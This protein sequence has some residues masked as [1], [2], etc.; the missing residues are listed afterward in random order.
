MPG[1]RSRG[2][3]RLAGVTN[4]VPEDLVKAARHH[5]RNQDVVS[6]SAFRP[7]FREGRRPGNFGLGWPKSTQPGQRLAAGERHRNERDRP[8]TVPLAASVCDVRDGL[9]REVGRSLS[10][11]CRRRGRYHDSVGEAQ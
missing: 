5:R 6:R 10:A 9:D 1:R 4:Q 7:R 3:K 11:D 8:A 2:A